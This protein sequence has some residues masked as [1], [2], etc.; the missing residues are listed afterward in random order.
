MA[1]PPVIN[2]ISD[3]DPTNPVGTDFIDKSDD[4]HRAIQEAI[5]ESFLGFDSSVNDKQNKSGPEVDDTLGRT[6]NGEISGTWEFVQSV[7][8]KQVTESV[9]ANL[10]FLSAAGDRR[11]MWTLQDDGNVPAHSMQLRRF[12]PAG[13][14]GGATEVSP[15][16]GS[17]LFEAKITAG[18]DI[19]SGG[20]VLAENTGFK[21]VNF[22]TT[23][24]DF[25]GT[26]I[27]SLD[28][29]GSPRITITTAIIETFLQMVINGSLVVGGKGTINGDLEINGEF[30]TSDIEGGS[31]PD[32]GGP[33]TKRLPIYN[34]AGVLQGTI[35]ID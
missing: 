14:F 12:D 24:M 33:Y 34:E 23:G 25:P 11:W 15:S 32:N 26:D 7:L 17:W 3:L 8:I 1:D 30:Q 21:S 19:V 28:T 29:A 18:G 35:R 13:T 5:L 27:L 22:P 6:E 16:D 9:I 20:T 4:W 31:F 2:G 10:E